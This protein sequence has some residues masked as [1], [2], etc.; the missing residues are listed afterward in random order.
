MVGKIEEGGRIGMRGDGDLR[1]GGSR[2]RVTLS[3][4]F[5]L[6]MLVGCAGIG[7]IF[8]EPDVHLDRV[9]LQGIG[10]TGGSLGLVVGVHN[11]NH[12]DLRGTQLQLGFDV[13]DAH[14]G[15]VTWENDFNITQGD[16]TTLTLP[17]NFT[18]AGVG[19]VVRVA[20]NSGEIPYTMKGQ[21]TVQ[22]PFGPRAV[23]FTHE[24][25]AP[26]TRERS[27]H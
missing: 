10:T 7:D 27:L 17:V 4:I 9:I 15:D 21:V 24:G 5:G 19:S 6:V 16:T 18:W 3:V 13:E 1:H 12:F 20:L 22:S 23:A 2:L 26:L 8:Q 25:R 11:P 14:V